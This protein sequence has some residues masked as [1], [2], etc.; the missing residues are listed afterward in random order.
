MDRRSFTKL[1]GATTMAASVSG[2]LGYDVVS[3]EQIESRQQQID[4][5]ESTV[6]ERESQIDSLEDE[7]ES[8]ESE[9]ATLE[10]TVSAKSGDID[11][12][13]S[14]LS[15]QEEE[16]KG[17]YSNL[18]V[19]GDNAYWTGA[20]LYGPAREHRKNQE[21][22]QA[23]EKYGGAAQ[24]FRA[25]SVAYEQARMHVD[26]AG[27]SEAASIAQEAVDASLPAHNAMSLLADAS[28][29]KALGNDSDANNLFTQAQDPLNLAIEREPRD[30]E[31]FNQAL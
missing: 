5:L 10:E 19:V 22:T 7:I 11:E 28:V 23:A 21:W 17:L 16:L 18:Y 29:A 1:V 15:T 30:P 6:E 12:L 26:D 14:Q 13:E 27:L 9:V 4:E 24:E 20:D 31:T 2:C 25:A 3:V 8:K